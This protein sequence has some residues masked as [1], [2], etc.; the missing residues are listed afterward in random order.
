MENETETVKWALGFCQIRIDSKIVTLPVRRRYPGYLSVTLN[1]L[2]RRQSPA[3]KISNGNQIVPG[4]NQLYG[5]EVNF[6]ETTLV[7]PTSSATG[8]ANVW[9]RLPGQVSAIRHL[10]TT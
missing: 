2:G 3:Q 4:A 7:A 6:T 10:D 1:E 9:T 5:G 8:V